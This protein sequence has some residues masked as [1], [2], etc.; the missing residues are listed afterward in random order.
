M[1]DKKA[2]I[3][4]IIWLILVLPILPVFIPVTMFYMGIPEDVCNFVQ[5]FLA[6][7]WIFVAMGSVLA[8][9]YGIATMDRIQIKIE[10]SKYLYTDRIIFAIMIMI[11]LVVAYY[12]Q[13]E[14]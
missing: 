5:H 12:G 8:C 14:M 11:S 2:K 9:M 13:F 6:G 1:G 4:T 7:V 3:I 10:D